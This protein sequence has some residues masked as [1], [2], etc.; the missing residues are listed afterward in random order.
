[1]AKTPKTM[2]ELIDETADEEEEDEEIPEEEIASVATS[3]KS[4]NLSV[5]EVSE[6][7]H[8]AETTG[9]S[10]KQSREENLVD[11]QK[12]YDEET[13]EYESNFEVEIQSNV[14]E[15][16]HLFNVSLLHSALDDISLPPMRR[17]PF[18]NGTR[19]SLTFTNDQMWEIER[20]NRLLM[21]R[22][23]RPAG[24]SRCSLRQS[25][26]QPNSRTSSA[27]INRKKRERQIQL[28]NQVLCRKLQAIKS[29]RPK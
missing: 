14:P 16:V 9:Q 10:V 11:S 27:A 1:M 29:R 28:D 12:D 17:R 20:Q 3:E 23:F 24:S 7:Q 6:P 21:E 22:I 19:Q 8:N 18:K 13:F 25:D 4:S 5:Q 15:G 2:V 26:F